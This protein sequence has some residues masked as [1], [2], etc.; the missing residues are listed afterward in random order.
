MLDTVKVALL[1]AIDAH[2]WTKTVDQDFHEFLDDVMHL[3]FDIIHE[4]GEKLEDIWA[5]ELTVENLQN[6]KNQTYDTLEKIKVLM[7]DNSCNYTKGTEFLINSKIDRLE[8]LCWTARGYAKMEDIEKQEEKE[9]EV[10]APTIDK[11]INI[12]FLNI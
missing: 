8:Y 10:I 5:W 4:F 1:Q 6:C 11:K 9:P 7:D 2:I 3:Y 12:P